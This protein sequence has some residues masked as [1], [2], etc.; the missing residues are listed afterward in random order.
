MMSARPETS[1]PAL[2]R[3]FST[4]QLLPF[5]LGGLSGPMG[6]GLVPVLFAVMMGAFGIDR[7]VL[8]LAVPAYM[9]PYAA[10]QLVSGGISDLTSRRTSLII[11]F[12][13]FGVATIVAGLAPTF[14]LFLLAEVLQGATN[15]FT[16]PVLMATLGD[17]VPPER[18]SRTMAFFN[19]SNLAGTMLAPLLGGILGS[20]SWRLPFVIF[21]LSNWVLLFWIILWFRRNS[22]AVPPA[23][24][25]KSLRADLREMAAALG[26]EMILLATLS[27]FASNA[28]RGAV[29]LYADFL[30]DR[31]GLSVGSAGLILATYGLAG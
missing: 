14:Q 24:R 23:V 3:D 12:G 20:I 5:Y 28:I 11:G 19:T 27:F 8:S 2:A 31:W 7:S 13:G 16:S 10:V 22:A 25:G 17:V 9:L 29:Y 30:S 6:G 1:A 26:L 21:G 18:M 15:A 4:W